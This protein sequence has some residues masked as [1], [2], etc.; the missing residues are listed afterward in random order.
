MS[1]PDVVTRLTASPVSPPPNQPGLRPGSD[2]GNGGKNRSAPGSPT[3]RVGV[4][5][6]SLPPVA[7]P[8]TDGG[9]VD[10]MEMDLDTYYRGLAAERLQRLSDG[11]FETAREA[12][13]ADAQ[14]AAWRLASV[15]TQLLDMGIE[16][17]QPGSMR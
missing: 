3:R 4:G 16:V 5:T 9:K 11:L 17:A 15:A 8:P 6:V 10:V 12:E 13:Q 2:S 14:E 7:L 1:R